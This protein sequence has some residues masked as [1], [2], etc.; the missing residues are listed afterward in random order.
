MLPKVLLQ[1]RFNTGKHW[2]EGGGGGGGGRLYQMDFYF[3]DGSSIVWVRDH[4]QILL[5]ILSEFKR[6]D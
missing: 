3:S 6:I 4:Q 5:L 2:K 1:L